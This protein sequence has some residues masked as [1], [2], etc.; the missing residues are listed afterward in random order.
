MDDVFSIEIDDELT[1]STT[2]TPQKKVD[3]YVSDLFEFYRRACRNDKW[4]EFLRALSKYTNISRFMKLR[5]AAGK[6]SLNLDGFRGV[7]D[8]SDLVASMY[9]D[10][11]KRENKV[12]PYDDDNKITFVLVLGSVIIFRPPHKYRGKNEK[13]MRNL[14]FRVVIVDERV[15]DEAEEVVSDADV[16]AAGADDVVEE[17]EAAAAEVVPVVV[18]VDEVAAADD[19]EEQS[20][21]FPS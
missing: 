9:M 20:V 11:G 6:W 15:G 7:I 19:E 3:I 12:L 18:V 2:T 4:P 13:W 1:T 21:R 16:V 14:E 5:Y 10:G 8:N 17:E